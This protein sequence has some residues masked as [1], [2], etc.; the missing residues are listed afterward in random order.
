M[1]ARA[2][3]DHPFIDHKFDAAA[4]AAALESLEFP[5]TRLSSP[6]RV[7]RPGVYT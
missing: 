4:F 3:Q 7:V 5:K 1:A 2:A 6:V